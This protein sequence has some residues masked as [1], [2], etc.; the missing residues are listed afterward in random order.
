M[1]PVLFLRMASVV[2]FVHAALHTVNMLFGKPEPGP[3]Q[4]AIAAMKSNQ[5]LLMGMTRSFWDFYLGFGFATSIL[6]LAESIVFWQLSS[7]AKT[8][9]ARLRWILATFTIGYLA[10]TANSFAYFFAPP[11][12][13]ELVIAMCLAL[14]VLTSRPAAKA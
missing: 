3:Q 8:G 2:T 1:K 4:I 6:L 10:L 9:A 13:T 5:F 12:A 7:L 14:A 11:V